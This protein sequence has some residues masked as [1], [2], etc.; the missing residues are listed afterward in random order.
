MKVNWDDDIPKS[1]GKIIHGNQTT[2]QNHVL[3]AQKAKTPFDLP[4]H[5]RK[6][7]VCPPSQWKLC[8]CGGVTF[9]RFHGRGKV[10]DQR[11]HHSS[12]VAFLRARFFRVSR[13]ELERLR[14]C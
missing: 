5:G 12:M 8:G 9:H 2:N 11:Q 6:G 13:V 3:K 14:S 4:E 10:P 7:R 1:Y